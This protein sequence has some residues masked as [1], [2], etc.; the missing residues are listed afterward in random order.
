[1]KKF[2]ISAKNV[3]QTDNGIP[4]YN[5]SNIRYADA[6][7]GFRRFAPPAPPP[8]NRTVQNSSCSVICPQALPM[9]FSI[10]E[11]VISGRRSFNLSGVPPFVPNDTDISNASYTE[12]CL[13]LDVLTTKKIYDAGQPVAPVLVFIH[14]GGFTEGSKVTYGPGVGLLKQAAGHGHDIVYV[15]INY[16]L[17]LFVSNDFSV[18]YR[19]VH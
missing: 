17:G 15:S 4:Y 14:G 3:Q 12:D 6:P 7:T 11:A 8:T 1:L 2:P 5:F 10:G 18:S 13:F 9:W 16:R 19:A